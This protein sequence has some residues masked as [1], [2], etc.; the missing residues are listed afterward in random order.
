MLTLRELETNP[1][2]LPHR[3]DVEQRLVTFL[4]VERDSLAQPGFLADRT[5]ETATAS[6]DDVLAMKPMAEP[7][8]FIFHTAFCRSTLL[9]R[10]MD[11]P[12]R[13]AVLNEPGILPSLVGG[14]EATRPMIAPIAALLGRRH[15]DGEVVLVK[16]TNHSN[17]LI[18]PLM[19]AVP[20]ARAVLMT[21]D[22]PV[23]LSSVDRKELM[24]RRWARQLFVELQSYVG[25]DFG[26]DA[27]ESFMLT[28]MQCAG[29]AWFLNQRYFAQLLKG[30]FG[31]RLRLL[32]GDR[33]NT[34][35]KATVGAISEFIGLGLSDDQ[36]AVAADGPVFDRN[37]KS[38]E[39]LDTSEVARDDVREEINQ[40]AEWVDIVATNAGLELTLK[41]TL[42]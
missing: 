39:R 30:E 29:L 9:I 16:P 18:V 32:D 3:I 6:W 24:G 11:I 42:F 33:F 8:H 21:N 34:T 28:D 36:I 27:R 40:A 10:A 41:Q 31:A 37:A 12:W 19:R 7:L 17:A 22:L 35:R 13:C 26:M 20:T 5:G 4:R 1:A 15:H 23:F 14:G 25:M 2:W 38:G